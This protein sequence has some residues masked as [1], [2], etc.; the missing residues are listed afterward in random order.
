MLNSQVGAKVRVPTNALVGEGIVSGSHGEVVSFTRSPS[1]PAPLVQLQ[2][3][4]GG[5]RVVVV[6][7]AN[8]Y[9]MA[10]GGVSRAA[11][12]RQIPLVLA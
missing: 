10:F 3:L 9:V 6:V 4:D 5:S 2:L 1:R 8:A 12:R 7:P 11:T